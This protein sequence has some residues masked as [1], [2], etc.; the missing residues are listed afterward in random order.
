MNRLTPFLTL[1]IFATV[2]LFF[3][4]N[5]NDDD[6]GITPCNWAVELADEAE[7]LSNAA[8]A[9]ANDPTTANCEA[10]RQAFQ[11]YLDEAED[12]NLCVPTTD[13]AEYQQAIDDAQQS[14]DDLQC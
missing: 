2:T 14:L 7:A 9:Y 12:L 13:Q 10:Y 5:N 11:D 1:L 8:T 6:G 3:A 4:C